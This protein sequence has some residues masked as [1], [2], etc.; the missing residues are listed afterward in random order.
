M[1]RYNS[2][3]KGYSDI[4]TCFFF[5]GNSILTSNFILSDNKL[6]YF[7]YVY[8]IF[9]D[10]AYSE[11][12]G[13]TFIKSEINRNRALAFIWFHFYGKYSTYFTIFGPSSNKFENLHRNRNFSSESYKTKINN[14]Y[15]NNEMI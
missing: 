5:Q 9:S 13:P 3:I 10:S 7:S 14:D 12:Y 6:S 1:F 15:K 8:S 11:D 2:N 4:F